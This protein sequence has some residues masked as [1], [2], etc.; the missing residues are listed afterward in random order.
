MSRSPPPRVPQTAGAQLIQRPWP[1]LSAQLQPQRLHGL[2]SGWCGTGH[3]RRSAE[4]VTS[5]RIV[6]SS[7]AISLKAL[8]TTQS[9]RADTASPMQS[10]SATRAGVPLTA[11][12]IH[13]REAS[14]PEQEASA[15][16][17]CP[18][19]TP[20]ICLHCTLLGALPKK[21]WNPS[22]ACL[23]WRLHWWLLSVTDQVASHLGHY[24]VSGPQRV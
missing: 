9:S 8:S 20:H 21:T 2:Q 12:G 5:G 10:K 6:P 17:A 22:G 3:G 15:G 14:V 19:G 11:S 16:Q 24:T 13:E 1:T 4:L 23:C 7:A 18:P